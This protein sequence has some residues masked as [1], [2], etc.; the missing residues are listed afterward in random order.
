MITD[1]AVKV[2]LKKKALKHDFN[3]KRI[4]NNLSG[5][6]VKYPMANLPGAVLEGRS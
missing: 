1:L 2:K 6:F 3:M 5:K 4:S